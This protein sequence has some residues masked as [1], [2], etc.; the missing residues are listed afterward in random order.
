[1]SVEPTESLRLLSKFA[2]GDLTE[3]LARI[4]ANARGL[5]ADRAAAFL[6]DQGAE[7]AVLTAVNDMIRL[8]YEE[9]SQHTS[10]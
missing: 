5:T 6:N 3:T 7:R 9:L 10:V 1:V 2:G 8:R 4:E